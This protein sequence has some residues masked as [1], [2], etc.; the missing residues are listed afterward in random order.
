AP[1]ARRRFGGARQPGGKAPLAPSGLKP[2]PV[3]NSGLKRVG[4]SSSSP[5]QG[6]LPPPWR[7][8]T[9]VWRRVASPTR[10]AKRIRSVNSGNQGRSA[11]GRVIERG[12]TLSHINQRQESPGENET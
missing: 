1:P 2:S 10:G 6:R 12:S 8:R 9:N 3:Q 11:N 5:Q 7:R 4:W